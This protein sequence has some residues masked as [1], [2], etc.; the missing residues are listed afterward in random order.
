MRLLGMNQD[1]SDA[2]PYR[3]STCV[4]MKRETKRSIILYFVMTGSLSKLM[5]I[6][7]LTYFRFSSSSPV[8]FAQLSALNE[9]RIHAFSK[10][11]LHISQQTTAVG[12]RHLKECEIF[13][14]I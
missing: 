11:V 10:L 6:I 9:K 8:P 14:A 4:Y 12:T 1:T 2:Y 13:M 5:D 3:E 7:L